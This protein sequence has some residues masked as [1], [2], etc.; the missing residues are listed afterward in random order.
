MEKYAT[1]YRVPFFNDLDVDKNLIQELHRFQIVIEY[2]GNGLWC[3][4]DP[5]L[6][7]TYDIDGEKEYESLPS[8]RSQEYLTRFR[9]S[10]E[11]AFQVARK[12]LDTHFKQYSLDKLHT[13]KVLE[14]RG[15][16]AKFI[17]DLL[18]LIQE[19]YQSFKDETVE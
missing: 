19:R 13:K 18:G 7:V 10:K 6:D 8:N 11:I 3:V 16:T 1:Q 4:K 14:E 9:F 2:R 12:A 15:E 5:T 17:D